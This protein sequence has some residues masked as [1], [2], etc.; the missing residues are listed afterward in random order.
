[1]R[2]VALIGDA[3]VNIPA[4]THACAIAR[5]A[6]PGG[7]FINSREGAVTGALLPHP[8]APD[9]PVPGTSH[10]LVNKLPVVVLG[11]VVPCGNTVVA[12][13]FVII[14]P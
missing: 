2:N 6:V 8:P 11:D 10:V 1:M 3:A 12:T 14:S 7:V 9:I 5:N 13:G 4:P